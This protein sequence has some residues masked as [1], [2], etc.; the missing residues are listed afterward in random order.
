MA[1]YLHEIIWYITVMA[2]LTNVALFY[3]QLRTYRRVGHRSLALLVASTVFAL[4]SAAL[5][6]AA[7]THAGGREAISTIYL[8]VAVFTTAQCA[9]GVW[10][11]SS[12]FRAFEELSRQPPLSGETN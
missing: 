9:I 7:L 3:L 1:G 8:I 10:G 11:T 12:L 2:L 4:G 6:V 5:L